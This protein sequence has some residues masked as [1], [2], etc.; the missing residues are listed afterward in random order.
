MV[1]RSLRIKVQ[2]D[3]L[4]D[5]ADGRAQIAVRLSA[6]IDG[7]DGELDQRAVAEILP[8]MWTLPDGTAS[9][10]PHTPKAWKFWQITTDA[11][12]QTVT[13]LNAGTAVDNT[14]RVPAEFDS[15]VAV[16]PGRFLRRLHEEIEAI[17]RTSGLERS[18]CIPDGTVEITGRTVFGLVESLTGLPHPIGVGMKVFTVFTLAPA[19]VDTTTRFIAAPLFGGARG[20]IYT[21]DLRPPTEVDAPNGSF[22]RAALT[23]QHD[24]N[25]LF[26]QGSVDMVPSLSWDQIS[27]RNPQQLLNM[28]TMLVEKP[29]TTGHYLTDSD[30]A[31]SLSRDIAKAIDP[32]TR[33]MTVL[34]QT[35]TEALSNP[36]SGETLK[37]ALTADLGAKSSD[38]RL[39]KAFDSIAWW[40]ISDRSSASAIAGPARLAI[41]SGLAA[42][43]PGFWEST[44][45]LVLA[46]A[47]RDIG[48]IANNT[49][50]AQFSSVSQEHM[51]ALIGLPPKA[52]S[53]QP[54]DGPEALSIETDSGLLKFIGDYW[55]G[56]PDLSLPPPHPLPMGRP[57]LVS[58]HLRLI[59]PDA[60]AIAASLPLPDP[61][62]AALID[63]AQIGSQLLPD[64]EAN[65]TFDVAFAPPAGNFT[66]SVAFVLPDGRQ[67]APSLVVEGTAGTT[68]LNVNVIQD[69]VM[70]GT[71]RGSKEPRTVLSITVSISRSAVDNSVSA[72]LLVNDSLSVDARRLLSSPFYLSLA[73]A[74]SDMTDVT[75][76]MPDRAS[77]SLRSAFDK[78]LTGTGLRADLALATI[79][80]F[81]PGIMV[82]R[83]T[84]DAPQPDP[85]RRTSSALDLNK[86]IAAS[87]AALVG[88]A[89]P[90]GSRPATSLYQIL[91][92]RALVEAGLASASPDDDELAIRELL[93]HLVENA[94]IDAV[95]RSQSLVP[96]ADDEAGSGNDASRK[97]A[98]GAPPL[99]FR[100]DQLQDMGGD[101]DFWTRLSGLG[102][103]IARTETLLDEV[104]AWRSLNVATIHAPP[105]PPP[106]AARDDLDPGNAVTVRAGGWATGSIVDPVA[107]QVGDA[108]GVRAALISY[109]NR[110]I[111]AEMGSDYS[112]SGGGAANP[113]R[114]EAYHYP[115]KSGQGA[116]LYRLPALSFG[117][118]FHVLAYVIGQGGPLPPLVREAP[119]DPLTMLV[120]E[121]AD[122]YKGQI[123]IASDKTKSVRRSALYRRTR[124]ISAPRL[125][126]PKLAGPPDGVEPL[127]AELLIRP[128][129]VTIGGDVQGRFFSDADGRCGTLEIRPGANAGLRV[130]IGGL[131]WS[132]SGGSRELTVVFKGR[133]GASENPVDLLVIKKIV[134]P[135]AV[136]IEILPAKT[137]IAFGVAAPKFS[138]DEFDFDAAAIDADAPTI[139]IAEWRNIQIIVKANTETDI[140]PPVA[141]LISGDGASPAQT[142]GK[143]TPSPE[144]GHQSRAIHVLDGIRVGRPSGLREMK[145]T[146]RR[147]SLDFSSYERWVN[148]PL[149]DPKVSTGRP[150]VSKAIDAAY[151]VSTTVGKGDRSLDDPAVTQLYVELVQIFPNHKV[152]GMQPLGAPFETLPDILGFGDD[153]LRT[154]GPERNFTVAVGNVEALN[155][156]TATLLAGKI[157]EVRIYGGVQDGQAQICPLGR[158]LRLSPSVK[159]TMRRCSIGSA[160]HATMRLG[161]P[162]VYTIEVATELM[163]TLYGTDPMSIGQSRIP[164]RDELAVIAF[165]DAFTNP[166]AGVY[167]V[168]RYCNLAVLESQ[169][170]S[171]RGRPQ[172][173]EWPWFDPSKSGDDQPQYGAQFAMAFSDRRDEDV[174][175]LLERRLEKAHAYAGRRQ[176]SDAHPSNVLAHLFD[177]P[178]D[179]RGGVNFWRFGLKLLNR[180]RSMRPGAG[181]FAVSSHRENAASPRWQHQVVLDRSTERKPKRP[182]LALVLP[183]TERF[184]THG[185]V[186]PLLALFNDQLFANFH[187]GDGIEVSVETARHPFTRDEQ[188]QCLAYLWK[189]LNPDT[190]APPTG[191][192]RLALQREYDGLE[193]DLVAGADMPTDTLKYWQEWGPDPI[194]IGE[195]SGGGL[196]PLRVDGPIGYTMDLGV[197]VGRFDHAGLLITPVG[198]D[199]S[200]WS[201]VKL[202]FRRLDAPEGID[203]ATALTA[204]GP[205]PGV[206]DQFYSQRRELTKGVASRFRLFN[207]IEV[208]KGH[209][210]KEFSELGSVEAD[211]V[212]PAEHEGL[213]IDISRTERP[214]VGDTVRFE[215]KSDHS[216]TTGDYVDVHVEAADDVLGR[217]HVSIKIST[218]LGEAG[219][220]SFIIKPGGTLLLRAIASL[221]EK[222]QSGGPYKPLGDIS[223]RA[224]IARD[225]SDSLQS[226]EENRW[227]SVACIPL[228][229]ADATTLTEPVLLA[230]NPGRFEAMISPVR[231]SPFTPAMWWQFGEAMSVF[232]ARFDGDKA[233]VGVD[234]LVATIATG[235]TTISLGLTADAKGRPRALSSLTASGQTTAESQLEEVLVIIATRFIHDAFARLREKPV[236]VKQWDALST[237]LD[238]TSPDWPTING[239]P[240]KL[241]PGDLG[242]EGNI[243]FLR[244][245]RPRT[246][247]A[248]GF[249]DDSPVFPLGMFQFETIEGDVDMNPPDAQ[250]M[251]LGI[252]MPIPWRRG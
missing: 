232:N 165:S 114:I 252:S 174:G 183:L 200:P 26:D 228:S 235:G 236:A 194:K 241:K 223:V 31:G 59:R 80:A 106:G 7:T 168:L 161:S 113:R 175:E 79:G 67:P 4:P 97:L 145:L 203:P 185:A 217:H 36:A 105:A 249:V 226:P 222:P 224:R 30:W 69:G 115:A 209:G 21:L 135:G 100:F 85:E 49:A 72:A 78:V 14:T 38:S 126:G 104:N 136:R 143:P 61:V 8:W 220:T 159:A 231:L 111:V 180:Y 247:T 230:V 34:D 66:L 122:P 118:A 76:V 211:G 184:M 46:A 42:R 140:E 84:W 191:D 237:T 216:H 50:R 155:G 96:T 166:D 213:V 172:D 233:H 39:L 169:R 24:P 188:K 11:S 98:A 131:D 248:G 147:P 3:R 41:L 81:V 141:T 179:W 123:K 193:R 227:L 117:Y 29:G 108:D 234:E 5:L 173:D 127:A 47:D 91:L 152:I 103:L 181:Q 239:A 101:I 119:D 156:D 68:F 214:S 28:A 82:G 107:L 187:A 176:L 16:Q 199:L 17:T 134:S 86:R 58:A 116:T 202:R 221:R 19:P 190:G 57:R 162:L 250:G 71:L 40:T 150:I 130:D 22:H 195:G 201:F 90:D 52:D 92:D 43:E 132:P 198:Q 125:T 128:P 197:E 148:P 53:S 189:R 218:H 2:T 74:Q 208:M 95:R 178:L 139:G 120:I 170:W 154:A 182:G 215:I 167:P 77:S 196:M 44:A 13:D 186:P 51:R 225:S 87:V 243:R 210:P 12:G 56:G 60:A 229:S 45:A 144:A 219:E 146:L 32:F 238:L 157:Y 93:A 129:P 15:D 153:K 251:V 23:A 149:F 142:I 245:L 27:T 204:Q 75:I 206:E 124:V 240:I 102:V 6:A 192:E 164:G 55:L 163:P 109:D 138:E 212:F 160:P 89:A 244:V 121:T 99:A 33:V 1:A 110:S 62:A 133:A 9:W 242:N 171:W 207:D 246:R 205:A 73:S 37:H 18:L 54:G 20:R 177:K 83:L 70:V 63:C 88:A 158:D 35:V 94:R 48:S 25:E 112:M 151:A 64:R 10:D 137:T 65:L